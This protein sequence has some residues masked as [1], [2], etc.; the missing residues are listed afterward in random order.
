MA[1]KTVKE[2]SPDYV[3]QEMLAEAII[4]AQ[5]QHENIVQ[6]IGVVTKGD[7]L[8]LVMQLCSH[9]SLLVNSI[10]ILYMKYLQSNNY[11]LSINIETLTWYDVSN[12]LY[13]I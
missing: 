6:L 1:V 10:A 4:C 8:L 9:G 5:L 3:R 11:L 12:G 2:S 13:C 7:P